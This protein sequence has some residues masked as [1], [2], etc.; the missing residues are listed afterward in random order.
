MEVC[1]LFDSY[2]IDINS[3]AKRE[4]INSVVGYRDLFPNVYTSKLVSEVNLLDFIKIRLVNY[5]LRKD[6][7]SKEE[8]YSLVGIINS[9]DDFYYALLSIIY[10]KYPIEIVPVKSHGNDNFSI[11]Y[12]PYLEWWDYMHSSEYIEARKS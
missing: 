11:E 1:Q 8:I 4:V 12:M 7:F 2:N 3:V 6:E 9:S 10:K 5:L